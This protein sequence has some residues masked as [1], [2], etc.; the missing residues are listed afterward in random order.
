MLIANA[1]TIRLLFSLNMQLNS[2]LGGF[3]SVCLFCLIKNSQINWK[4]LVTLFWWILHIICQIT[5]WMSS[6]IYGWVISFSFTMAINYLTKASMLGQEV[7]QHIT[8]V[9]GCKVS[10]TQI[11]VLSPSDSGLIAKNML[12]TVRQ[13][14]SPLCSDRELWDGLINRSPLESWAGC[15]LYGKTVAMQVAAGRLELIKEPT[16]DQRQENEMAFD[17]GESWR[18]TPCYRSA[19]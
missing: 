6:F 17:P 10:K 12:I 16:A 2:G 4:S 1:S 7:K 5:N 15:C 19:K 13:T 18:V 8:K 3:F 9:C 11:A 14:L